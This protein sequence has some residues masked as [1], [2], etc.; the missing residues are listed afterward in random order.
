MHTNAEQP[1]ASA[2][3]LTDGHPDIERLATI[4]FM[5]RLD[6]REDHRPTIQRLVTYLGRLVDLERIRKILVVGCGPAPYTIRILRELGFEAFGVE[7]VVDFVKRAREYLSDE[8]GVM[9]GAAE[10]IPTPDASVDLVMCESVVEHIESCRL[11]FSEFYRV[12]RPGGLLWITTTNRH[13]FSLT[14]RNGEFRVRFFN[15]LPRLVQECYVF[16]QLHYRPELAN[17]TSRP[18][19]HWFS[20]ADLCAVGR[21]AGFAQFYSIIDLVNVSDPTIARSWLRRFLV[22][23]IQRS[24]WLRALALTQAPGSIVM[25]KRPV[26][27]SSD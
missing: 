10:S 26:A 4:Q 18:A 12:L 19:V 9:V 5:N 27:H 22:R 6:Q 7:P 23:R 21:E 8:Q 14:G 13:R 20:Y 11:S 17:Y 3:R 16:Q 24:A 2:R 15:W 1:T 25:L